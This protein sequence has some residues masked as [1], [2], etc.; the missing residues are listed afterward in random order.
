VELIRKMIRNQRSDET[1]DEKS[2]ANA[3]ITPRLLDSS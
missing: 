2:P 3:W 1:S